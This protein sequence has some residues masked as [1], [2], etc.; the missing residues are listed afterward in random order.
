MWKKKWIISGNLILSSWSTNKRY[1]LTMW[2]HFILNWFSICL[3]LHYKSSPRFLCLRFIKFSHFF[4]SP[5]F[6]RLTSFF[7]SKKILLKMTAIWFMKRFCRNSARDVN[8]YFRHIQMRSSCS[9]LFLYFCAIDRKKNQIQ[10]HMFRRQ[11]DCYYLVLWWNWFFRFVYFWVTWYS[12]IACINVKNIVF[13]FLR[14]IEYL[15]KGQ[16]GIIT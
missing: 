3:L 16:W 8:K 4:F 10:L 6:L 13:L 15:W 11:S 12:Q 5:A 2:V 7:F 1:R 14:F 9:A